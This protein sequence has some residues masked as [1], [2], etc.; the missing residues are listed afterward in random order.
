MPW[1]VPQ[2]QRRLDVLVGDG[3]PGQ[4]G[5]AVGGERPQKPRHGAAGPGR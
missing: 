3:G 4:A 2:R 1:H 5:R